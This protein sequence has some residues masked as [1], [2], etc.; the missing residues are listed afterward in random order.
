M[1]MWFNPDTH[2]PLLMP[3]DH[4]LAEAIEELY[5]RTRGSSDFSGEANG[6]NPS[7]TVPPA[8]E[9]EDADPLQSQLRLEAE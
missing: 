4:T 2:I 3:V 6:E 9:V 7:Q 8:Q 1:T 5:V